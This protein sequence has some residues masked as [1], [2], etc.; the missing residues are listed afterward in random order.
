VTLFKTDNP[1]RASNF[2]LIERD[3]ISNGDMLTNP[4]TVE[5]WQWWQSFTLPGPSRDDLD[6]ALFPHLAANI[7]LI[8]VLGPEKFMYRLCGEKVGLLVGRTYRMVKISTNSE[9]LQDQLLS[10]YL[11]MLIRKK[12]PCR[13]S[14][15]LSFF[16]HAVVNFESI[17]CPLYDNYGNITHF[18]GVLSELDPR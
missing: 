2:N 3:L 4:N 1:E 7:Y 12:S 11:A 16:N 15:N 13:C 14:G 10:Q 8:E 9:I 17:D 5:L 18:V 6:I